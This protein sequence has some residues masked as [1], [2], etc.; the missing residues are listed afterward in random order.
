MPR[1]PL[2]ARRVA[3]AAAVAAVARHASL[4]KGEALD[5]AADV[6]TWIVLIIAPII[7][8]AGLWLVHIL[9]EKI[10]EKKKH[11]QAKAI[12]VLCL[13]SLASAACSGRLLAMGL[14]QTGAAQDGLWHRY[15]GGIG[16]RKKRKFKRRKTKLNNSPPACRTRSQL[17][18]KAATDGGKA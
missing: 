3:R 16:T 11:P 14:H 17:A 15:R 7:A 1:R 12:Q 4:F 9:P 10:A 13:L 5:K 6:L 8:I 2:A 18:G